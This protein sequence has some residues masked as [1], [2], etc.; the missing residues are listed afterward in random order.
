M[1]RGISLFKKLKLFASKDEEEEHRDDNESRQRKSTK[2]GESSR[3]RHH[4]TSK[5]KG[6]D[7][8]RIKTTTTSGHKRRSKH[9]SQRPT[10]QEPSD[11]RKRNY[12]ISIDSVSRSEVDLVSEPAS[13]R[14]VEPKTKWTPAHVNR[15]VY[16]DPIMTQPLKVQRPS[17]ASRKPVKVARQSEFHVHNPARRTRG[18]STRSI[19]SQTRKSAPATSKAKSLTPKIKRECNICFEP[20]SDSKFFSRLTP[21]CNHVVSSCKTCIRAYLHSRINDGGALD[22]RCLDCNATIDYS[23]L[24]KIA[25]SELMT[26]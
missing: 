9:K 16:A 21:N 26:R 10:G 25:T 5:H 1:N 11:S 17:A 7:P 6:E 18:S 8:T 2:K 20:L 4:S 22:L 15:M 13:T 24:M 12:T 14:R 23:D 19:S 3:K